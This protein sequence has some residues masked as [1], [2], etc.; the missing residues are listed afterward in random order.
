MPPAPN[1]FV[2][3]LS[4]LA[5]VG[6]SAGCDWLS[7]NVSGT[8]GGPAADVELPDG[9]KTPTTALA[10]APAV[11]P[12]VGVVNGGTPLSFAPL[13]EKTLPA[14]A[15]VVTKVRR[16][17]RHVAKGLGTAFFYD[18]RGFMLTNNHVIKS[19]TDISVSFP[20]GQ[21]FAAT[22][23]GRDPPTDVAVL[24]IDVDGRKRMML[25]L[26]DSDGLRVGDWTLAIGNPFGL[27]HSVSAGI[28]SGKGRNRDDVKGILQEG[29]VDFL[30]TDAS[31]NPGNS[32]GPLVNL[33]GEVV[34]VNTAVRADANNIGFAIP[35]NMV[36]ELLPRLIADGRVQRSKIGVEVMPVSQRAAEAYGRKDRHGAV[37]N[38][39]VPGGPADRAGL[40]PDDLILGFEGEEVSD[41]DDLRWRASIHGADKQ[42]TLRVLREGREF[43]LK[44]K[45]DELEA[46]DD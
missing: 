26:G 7:S 32:G 8:G 6:T 25:P 46:P 18:E 39:V 5:L 16:S 31:I 28:L 30:Q 34:G 1:R 22:V 43:D 42:A 3:L 40:A 35:I 21:E 24:K 36:K 29:Y 45:L 33:A 38:R 9:A 2:W 23:V 10:P 14:V 13:V 20:D 4:G 41:P 27:S 37:V 19:A 44:V 11:P 17:R 15:T 12:L